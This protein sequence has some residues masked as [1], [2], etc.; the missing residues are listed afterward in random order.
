[1][2]ILN[3]L[4]GGIGMKNESTRDQ[5]IIKE[6]SLIPSGSRILDAGAGEMRYKKFCK[7]LTYVSQDSANY[8]GKGDSTG[9]QTGKWDAAKVDII[10]DIASIPVPDQSFDAILCSEVF[11]HI[12]EPS[13]AL[14]E[15]AR[16]LKPNGEL[17]LSA[18]FAALT[19]F[20]PEF[21]SNGYSEYWYRRMLPESGFKINKIIRNGTYFSY[22][23]QEI[24]RLP[25]VSRKY[26]RSSRFAIFFSRIFAVPLLWLVRHFDSSDHGSGDLLC[27]G[28]F[29]TAR[30]IK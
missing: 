19:H 26:A 20:A 11:E 29:I 2:K 9:L 13:K 18:P 5:W 22:L 6:L 1:M 30:K 23:A 17:I 4:T 14:K 25:A 24:R 15:F 7:H 27:H 8:T 28:L 3:K 12:P 10:S 16:V 21:Y